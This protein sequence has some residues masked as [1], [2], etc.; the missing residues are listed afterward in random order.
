MIDD[1]EAL[2]AL[3]DPRQHVEHGPLLFLVEMVGVRDGEV[4]V[5]VVVDPPLPAPGVDAVDQGAHP[6]VLASDCYYLHVVSLFGE[7]AK[8]AALAGSGETRC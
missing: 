2:E 7:L 3:L 5:E 6:G 1:L 8:S 4:V